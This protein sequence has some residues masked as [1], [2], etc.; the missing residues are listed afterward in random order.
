MSNECKSSKRQILKAYKK[1][2]TILVTLIGEYITNINTLT[3]SV[4]ACCSTTNGNYEDLIESLD[5][6]IANQTACCL[7]INI[8]LDIMIQLIDQLCIYCIEVPIVTTTTEEPVTP[9]TTDEPVQTT[10]ETSEPPEDVCDEPTIFKDRGSWYGRTFS[11]YVGTD[12]GMITFSWESWEI[13]DRFV[14]TWGGVIRYDTGYVGDPVTEDKLN[15]KLAALGV[16]PVT[17]NPATSGTANVIKNTPEEYVDVIVYA[18]LRNT[19]FQFTVSCPEPYTTTTS[20]EPETTTSS[21]EEEV[22]TTSSES[23]AVTTSSDEES[24]TTSSEAEAVTTSSEGEVATTSSHEPEAT[25]SSTE[26]EA[27]T[28]TTQ[29]RPLD[30]NWWYLA[31][32]IYFDSGFLD[33]QAMTVT[34]A[35]TA[36]RGICVNDC[37][38]GYVDGQDGGSGET[39]HDN[40]DEILSNSDIVFDVIG[41]DHASCDIFPEG[42]YLFFPHSTPWGYNCAFV[43]KFFGHID[44]TGHVTA[45]A[46]CSEDCPETTT[47]STEEPIITTSSP[48]PETTTSS[49]EEPAVTTSSEEPVITTSSEAEVVTTSTEEPVTTTTT[50]EEIITTSSEEVAVT[51]S[52]EEPEITTSTEEE[53]VTTSTEEEVITTSSE[54]EVITT[55]SEEVAVTSS[56]EAETVT[57]STEEPV[58]TTSS[59]EE[60]VTTSSEAEVITTSSEESVSTTT[61]EQG[62]TTSSEE[63]V[64]TTTEEQGITT[65]SEE[66]ISTTTEEQGITT[67]S[68]ESVSTTTEE[69]GITTSSTE[70][71]ENT[72]TSTNPYDE[73]C[74]NIIYYHGEQI[75]MPDIKTIYL[76]AS[77]GF[78]NLDIATSNIPDR[79]VIH[80]DGNIVIDTGFHGNYVWDFGESMRDAFKNSLN[81]Y[82]DPVSGLAYGTDF[83]MY[84]DDGYPRINT[85]EVATYCF[86][87][88]TATDFSSVYSYMPILGSE[89]AYSLQCPQEGNCPTASTTT[90][91]EG[92]TTTSEPETTTSTEAE[93]ITTTTEEPVATTSTEEPAITTS[94]EE[95]VVTTSTEPETTTTSTEEPVITTS[96]EEPTITTTTEFVGCVEYGYLYNLYSTQGSG[97]S[98]ITSSDDWIVPSSANWVT[99]VN[100]LGGILVAGG[101]LKE[102]GYEHWNSPNG[103]ATNESGF[104]ALGAGYRAGDGQFNNMWDRDKDQASFQFTGANPGLTLWYE[105]GRTYDFYHWGGEGMSIRLLKTSTILTNGQT[106]TYIG[107]DGMVYPTICIGTQEWLA[108][109]LAETETRDHTPLTYVADNTEWAALVTEGYCAYDNNCSYVGCDA[110]CPTATTSTEEPLVTTST[111]EPVTTTTTE[112]PVTTTTEEPVTTTTE[113][114]A[115]T[116]TTTC[117]IYEYGIEFL[118]YSN[119]CLACFNGT[120][121]DTL[122]SYYPLAEGVTLYSTRNGCELSGTTWPDTG[123][124]WYYVLYEGSYYTIYVHSD[125]AQIGTYYPCDICTTTTEEPVTTTTE[126]PVATTTEEPGTTTTT[127]DPCFLEGIVECFEDAPTTS[128]STEEPAMTTTTTMIPFDIEHVGPPTSSAVMDSRVAVSIEVSPTGDQ[129][130]ILWQDG[131]LLSYNMNPAWEI[132]SIVSNTCLVYIKGGSMQWSVDGSKLYTCSAYSN[133]MYEYHTLYNWD[134]AGLYFVRE[135]RATFPPSYGLRGPQ[136]FWFTSDGTRCFVLYYRFYAD[137]YSV[138]LYYHDLST[139]WDISSMSSLKPSDIGIIYSITPYI[140]GLEF[141]TLAN[142][143]YTLYIF[144]TSKILTYSY[145]G[146]LLNPTLVNDP[147]DLI[148]PL[149]DETGLDFCI[150]RNG[151]HLLLLTDASNIS[152]AYHFNI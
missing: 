65:S 138:R 136:T 116:T 69:Q 23:E 9:T 134:V 68:E 115:V 13:P 95:V 40:P 96:T 34:D 152:K 143:L 100:Y 147:Y 89:L 112:K 59:E 106:G 83:A 75:L 6:Y 62:I 124:W 103:G 126:E 88:L 85:A 7:A 44:G 63:S 11:K 27:V 91:E 113:E 54:E 29:C 140:M 137:A 38:T 130:Y 51:T 99:L 31:R 107:N 45:V 28:T 24:V 17:V 117:E 125:N 149:N 131:E 66:S 64:S 110:I 104:N 144:N 90:E 1:I 101:K 92:I 80:F 26:P 123:G 133:M 74:G 12:S 109:N 135:F 78:V 55:S 108:Y 33:V 60:V 42:T 122:Y 71:P 139:A 21:S 98:N 67:S 77:T 97:A 119:A 81:G 93:V 76:G 73:D 3:A 36:F 32:I 82:S 35:C 10:T 52:S 46:Q 127:I 148:T 19:A 14:L 22:I 41:G 61:E 47:S 16:A 118:G 30:V 72:T 132:S 150:T 114:P 86:D 49:S 94:S 58:I 142:Y 70:E 48:E 120:I 5:T 37:A 102:T 20:T 79:V 50:E 39:V 4:T 43:N 121:T 87:K 84:P 145:E 57:T 146:T 53:T 151:L 18:P 111:E 105:D 129:L 56:T 128:T 15:I 25:S 141:S 2:S 8:K